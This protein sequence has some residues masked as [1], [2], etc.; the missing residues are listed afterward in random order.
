MHNTDQN[1]QNIG[2]EEHLLR[3]VTVLMPALTTGARLEGASSLP[4]ALASARSF[5]RSLFA[6][7]VSGRYLSSSLNVWVAK[8]QQFSDQ[9]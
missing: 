3:V 2:S 6:S 4:A 8:Q 1:N 5:S 9:N 7:F